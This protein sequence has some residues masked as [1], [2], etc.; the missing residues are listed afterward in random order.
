MARIGVQSE[1]LRQQSTTVKTGAAEV[2]DTLGRLTGQIQ[3]LAASWEGAA[4]A[5]FQARWQEWQAGATQVQQ[6]MD[7]MGIFLDEA[8]RAYEETEDSLRAAAGR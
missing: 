3:T 5:A 8:A 1:D 6:A 4:S 2:N 7:S